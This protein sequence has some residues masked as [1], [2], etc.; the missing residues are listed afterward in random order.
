MIE[1]IRSYG[2]KNFPDIDCEYVAFD[3]GVVAI[4]DCIFGGKEIHVAFKRGHR[5]KARA[6]VD[7]LCNSLGCDVWALIEDQYKHAVNMAK[8]LGFVFICKSKGARM[9]GTITEVHVL[10]RVKK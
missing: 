10:K 3:C 8:K 6:C 9:D 4:R 7:D 5:H 1:L 2:I